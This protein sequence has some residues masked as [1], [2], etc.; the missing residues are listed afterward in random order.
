MRERDIDVPLLGSVF[1]LRKGA[2]KKMHCGDIPGSYVA[3]ELMNEIAAE[4]NAD[5]KGRAASL[6]RAAHADRGAQGL[7]LP[8]RAHRGHDPEIR[9]G[10]DHPGPCEGTG[11]RVGGMRRKVSAMR[12]AAHSTWAERTPEPPQCSPPGHRPA[13]SCV[14]GWGV[15]TLMRGLHD[16]MFV[17][18]GGLSGIMRSV[19][20]AIDNSKPLSAVTHVAERAVKEVLFDCRDCG[21]CALPE[22]Q[23][24]CPQSQCPKQERNGPCGG[25]RLDACEVYPDRPCVWHRVYCPGESGGRNWMRSVTPSSA[26]ATGRSGA[27]PA[28]R[29]SISEGIIRHMSLGR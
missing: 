23:F 17:K 7:G 8:W 22:L 6:E 27:P 28:G 25:S 10:R 16:V 1:I 26:R 14:S 12:R 24:L 11:L 15:F 2:C 29:T 20:A 21:D 19:T 5:D 3:D 18:Q 4:A 9:H 13:A